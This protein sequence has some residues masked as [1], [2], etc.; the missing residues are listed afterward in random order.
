MWAQ[1]IKMRIQ[2]GKEGEVVRLE[3]QWEREVGRGTD[4]GW[5]RTF[6]L[7]STTNPDEQYQ[8]VFFES[9]D[10]ARANERSSK[11]QEILQQLQALAEGGAEYVDLDPVRESRR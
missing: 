2:P 7:R 5:L 4:S 8:L 1:F 10:K 11:H 6:R 3:E 9:E